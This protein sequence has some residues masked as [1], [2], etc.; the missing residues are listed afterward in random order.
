MEIVNRY[1]YAV[2]QKLPQ[3]QRADIE[4]ELRGLIEDMMEE[5]MDAGVDS[6]VAAEEVLLELG[7]PGKLADQYRGAPR[8]LIGPEQFDTFTLVLKVVLVSI[9]ISLTVVFGIQVVLAPESILKLFFSY[10]CSLFQGVI[11]G[12]AWTALSFL[13][14][15]FLGVRTGKPVPDARDQWRPSQLPPVP[16]PKTQIKRVDTIFAIVFSIFFGLLFTFAYDLLG[17]YIKDAEQGWSRIPFFNKD[18]YAE[19]LP[20]L[21]VNS[22]LIVLTEC[23]KLITRKW[24]T[25]IIG[26]RVLVNLVSIVLAF[27]MF[28]NLHLWNPDFMDQMAV[29]GFFDSESARASVENI[30]S[31]VQLRFSMLI[32]LIAVLD[33]IASVWKWFNIR[34]EGNE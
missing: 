14:I 29:A 27:V 3:N 8:F 31:E 20:L 23:W 7:V 13:L 34:K 32:T 9:G 16:H 22:V 1:I 5:R 25:V 2:T 12:F 24:T 30:W 18:V 4:R 28:G 26:L 11:H 21:V 17:I 15:E 6:N 19:Y 10:V 33:I